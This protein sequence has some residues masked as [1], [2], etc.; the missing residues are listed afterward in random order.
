MLSTDPRVMARDEN[1]NLIVPMRP[2]TGLEAVAILLRSRLNL[3][4]DEWFL[5]RDAGTPWVPTEDGVVT[6]RDAI[7][8][9]GADVERV[10]VILSSEARKEPGV[11]SVSGLSIEVDTANRSMRGSMV[12]RTRFGDTEI[13]V[14]SG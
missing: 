7:L 11:V 13:A 8:A 14:S 9:I 3:W 10:Q 4:R 2:A 12:V 1:G 5:D 6:D